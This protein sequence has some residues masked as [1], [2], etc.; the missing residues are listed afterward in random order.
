MRD[1]M[2][3]LLISKA[4][5]IWLAIAFFTLSWVDVALGQTIT[6][7]IVG[8]VSDGGG[9]L[10]GASVTA[11]GVDTGFTYEAK[12]DAQGGYA[13]QGLRPGMYEITASVDQY[14]PDTRTVQ[15]LVGRTA[16]L[17]FVVIASPTFAENVEVVASPR[18][19]DTRTSE[20]A[21]VITQEQVRFLPQDQRNFLN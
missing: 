12:T 15:V 13:L 8:T 18:L 4:P 11:K 17:D 6:A 2:K 19:A 7:N 5:Q 14:K 16:T 3:Q 20:I 21:T 10:A 9:R 1:E